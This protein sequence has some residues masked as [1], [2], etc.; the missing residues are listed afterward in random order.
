MLQE[1]IKRINDLIIIILFIV[2]AIVSGFFL[3][4]YGK[5]VSL[6]SLIFL[7]SIAGFSF[8]APVLRIKYGGFDF[9]TIFAVLPV[10]VIPI[11]LLYNCVNSL[12]AVLFALPWG[13]LMMFYYAW[14]RR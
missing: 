4:K 12:T 5:E 8:I 1:K 11:L 13:I 10:T 9:L 7:S 6:V 2:T 14:L 3:S